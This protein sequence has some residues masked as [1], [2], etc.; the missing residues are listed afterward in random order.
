MNMNFSPSTSP[1]K[2]DLLLPLPHGGRRS[3][4]SRLYVFLSQNHETVGGPL[5]T[6][7]YTDESN[8]EESG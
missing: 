4:R 1:D 7:G 5:G 8:S 2:Y 6:E 3:P